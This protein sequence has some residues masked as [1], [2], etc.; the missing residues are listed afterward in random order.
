[1]NRLHQNRSP[2]R[3]P[4]GHAGPSADVGRSHHGHRSLEDVHGT[5]EVPS[6]DAGFWRQWRA[7]V[8]PAILVSVGY[9]DPGN[10][11]TDLQGGAQYKYGLLWVVAL[12]SIMAIF[13]QVIAARMGVVTG[14]DLAQA[15]RDWYPSWSRWPNWLLCELAIAACD[16]AEVLGSAVA[17]NL[18]FHIPLFWAVIITGFDV[19]ILLALQR[20]GMRTIEAVVVLLVATIGVCYFIEIFVLPKVQP[21]FLEMGQALIT[22]SFGKPGMLYVAIGIIGATVMPHNLYLHSALVQSRKLQKDDASIRRAIRF[23]TI[24]SVVA[25]SIAFLVNAGIMV[26]AAVVFYGKE[27][28]IVPGGKVVEFATDSDWIRVAYLTLAPLMGTAAASTLFAVALLASGQSSTITGTLAGQIVMEGFMHWQIKPWVRRL[29]TRLLA[30]LP[31][32][33]IIGLHG[34]GSVTDLLLLSQVIL[35]LQ[36]PLAMFPLLHFTSS[37]KRMGIWRNGWFLL[38][39]GWASAILITA[40]DIYGLPDSLNAAWRVVAGG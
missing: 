6:G 38:A 37:R 21:S 39:A 4:H 2:I 35:A 29:I 8:G 22:P 3:H 10:W 1:M 36:L 5:V 16:L 18:L 19:L 30:I 31:A 13:M 25:L 23:N 33:F 24:D 14:K 28:V 32:I 40:L 27:S 20:Y 11:G 34:D 12:A 7:Y 9:M 17:L 15:C 26:L